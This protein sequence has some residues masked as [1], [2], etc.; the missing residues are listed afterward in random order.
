[1]ITMDEFSVY[2]FYLALKLHFTTDQYDV[3][4]QKGKIRAT[5]QAFYK[6]KDLGTLKRIAKNYNDEEVV[7]FLVANFVSGDRWG[8]IFDEQTNETYTTW[9]KRIES[10]TYNYTN[11]LN[12]L[13]MDFE[14]Q[15]LNFDTLFNSNSDSHPYIIRHYLG[16]RISIETM[17][18]LDIIFNFTEKFDV[19]LKNDVIWPDLSRLIKKIS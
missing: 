17:V 7:N 1:M 13:V 12:T 2:R 19:D 8:G 18:I 3:I 9:K 10:L 16:K 5:K 4:K 6:R 14:Q 11:D 15:K